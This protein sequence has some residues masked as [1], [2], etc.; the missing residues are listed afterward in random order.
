MTR[1]KNIPL[2]KIRNYLVSRGLKRIRTTGGQK[3]WGGEGLQRPIVLQSH[4]DP[5]PEFIVRQILRSLDETDDDLKQFLNRS[6]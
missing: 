5:I 6:S 4:I 2:G 1:F 3:I